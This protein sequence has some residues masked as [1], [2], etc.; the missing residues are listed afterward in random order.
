GEVDQTRLSAVDAPPDVVVEPRIGVAGGPIRMVDVL[1][2]DQRVRR[3]GLR[4]VLK[5]GAVVGVLQHVHGHCPETV[6]LDIAIPTVP[7]LDEKFE[8]SVGGSAGSD[9]DAVAGRSWGE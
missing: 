3:L 2:E 7:C 6:V 1:S 9:L 4:V 8:L 5:D